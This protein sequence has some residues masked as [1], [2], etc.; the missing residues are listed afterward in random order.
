MDLAALLHGTNAL[1]IDAALMI[2]RVGIGLCFVVHALL[3]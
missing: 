2:G 1:F 3:F